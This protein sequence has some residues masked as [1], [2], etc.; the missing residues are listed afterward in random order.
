MFDSGFLYTY[1]FT[2]ER[3]YRL[4]IINEE[5]KQVTGALTTNK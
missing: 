1:E 5:A 2:S 3:N 4:G